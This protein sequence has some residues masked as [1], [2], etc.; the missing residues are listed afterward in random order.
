M[1]LR[2][3]RETD[4]NHNK[5]RSYV[6]YQRLHSIEYIRSIEF[7]YM[8]LLYIRVLF[9]QFSGEKKEKSEQCKRDEVVSG[10]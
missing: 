5:K 1:S 6:I 8:P 9:H 4:N 3:T 10:S 7:Y 2:S